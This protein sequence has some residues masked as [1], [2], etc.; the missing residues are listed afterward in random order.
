MPTA[1]PLSRLA[2][3]AFGL[4]G[5]DQLATAALPLVAVL[6]IGAGPQLVGALLAAQ[7]AAWLIF[8][9]PAG[10]LVD[11]I[12][13]TRLLGAA[14][15]AAAGGATLALPAVAGGAPAL[16]GLSAFLG[17]CGTVLFVLAAGSLVPALVPPDGLAPANARL[18]LARAVASL[19]APPLVGLLA[20]R[21]QA[22]AAFGLAIGAA[23]LAFAAARGLPRLAAPVVATRP[24]IRAQLA[25]GARFVLGHSLLRGIFGC[26]LC[27]NFS[28]FALLAA[29]VPFALGHLGLDPAR[30]GLAQ[31]GYGAGM[32]AGAAAAAPVQRR[33]GPN[34]ILLAG[35]GLSVAAP[36]L[37]LAAPAGGVVLP[38]AALFLVGF[39]PMM[40]LICQTGIRQIVTPPAMLGRVGA[41]LQV[42]IYGV[43]PL[44]ALLAGALGP[45]GGV[46]LAAAGFT[47]SLVV[48]AVSDLAGLR[49]LPAM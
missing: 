35:P 27:W 11:R 6:A 43:R 49:R 28:F 21:G 34:T 33:F 29:I 20:G 10:L 8:S 22:V 31:A 45:E 17:A 1:T 25:E 37:L 41:V 12:G 16:L 9:L 14:T 48:V 19:G 3:A 36:I 18:E 7:A 5:A 13:R 15:L 46:M 44:G 4:H 39:G 47:A 40:W 42:A 32:I 26:A 24:P 38:F 23:L 30:L 2:L